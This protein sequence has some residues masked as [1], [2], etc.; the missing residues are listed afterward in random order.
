MKIMEYYFSKILNVSY[1]EAVKLIGEALK[2]EGFGVISEINMHEKLKEKLD[3]DFKR[4]KILGACNP[5]YAYKALQAED[6]IGTMMPCNV[7]VI[8]Q[9]SNKI[10]I[11]A[12]NPLASMQAIT[13]PALGDIA[14]EVTN[15]LKK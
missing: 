8:E 1:D 4:Y 9:G 2:S 13:N 5:P 14:L 6:K 10:E 15:K 12:V 3:V 7:L 11:A